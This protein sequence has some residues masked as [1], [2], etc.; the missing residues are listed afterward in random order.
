[1]ALPVDPSWL[2]H[3]D[4]DLTRPGPL[5]DALDALLSRSEATG[6][7]SGYAYGVDGDITIGQA[8]QIHTHVLATMPDV[9]AA[10]DDAAEIPDTGWVDVPLSTG[11]S[12][13][14][15][16][17]RIGDVV[18]ISGSSMKGTGSGA[19]TT[20]ATLAA[21]YRPGAGKMVY[22]VGHPSSQTVPGATAVGLVAGAENQLLRVANLGSWTNGAFS[23][24]Y[25]T[26]EP[27]PYL[28]G[29][30]GTKGGPLTGAQIVTRSGAW[31][32]G[33]AYDRSIY[34]P[35][36]DGHDYRTSA[37]GYVSMALHA[38]RSFSTLS[39]VDVT[40]PISVEDLEPGDLLLAPGLHAV[41]FTG[42]AD[43][44]HTT[45]TGRECRQETGVVER[46][47]TYP[48][49]GYS[50]YFYPARYAKKG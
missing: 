20:V 22:G 21:G 27:F 42:W 6:T 7:V 38:D 50:E 44:E 25:T 14:L 16:V 32:G 12:G 34:A 1:M 31:L 18:H 45:Y 23:L 17:R 48:Y 33:T 49:E 46:T 13:T 4:A 15:Q 41:L 19:T 47:V 26:T 39:L 2:L 28:S 29:A 8:L 3:T 10:V 43:S 24:T 5:K 40:F 9:E 11:W 37:A 35:D 30:S 36:G